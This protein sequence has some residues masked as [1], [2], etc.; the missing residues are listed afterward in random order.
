MSEP[1]PWT[2]LFQRI[3]ASVPGATDAMIRL[4]ITA[5]LVDW[6]QDTNCW[7]EDV[8]FVTAQD[9]VDYEMVLDGGTANRLMLVFD[10]TVQPPR[11]VMNGISMPVP[12]Q[13]HFYYAP[14][15]GKNWVARIAKACSTPAVTGT[16]PV[17]TGY[18]VVDDWIID[19]WHDDF[20]YG[21][22]AYLQG[23]PSKTFSDP[24]SSSGA[25]VRYRSG[26]SQAKVEVQ[27]MN[28][29]GGQA[30]SYPQG[31]STIS[32]KGWA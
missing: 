23:E 31:W 15:P 9:E 28:L 1:A 8:P 20:Y 21:V 25:G 11:W 2:T 10:P 14:E 32:R 16:P 19:K 27:R 6:T 7:T 13:L 30:W 24:K 22:L 18:P 5:V 26:K 3:K 29:Y 4:E 17:L 12:G